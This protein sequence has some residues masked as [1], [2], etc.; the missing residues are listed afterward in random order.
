[1]AE[2]AAATLPPGAI[3]LPPDGGRVYEMNTMR[4]V[5]K[6]DGDETGDRYCVSEW[7]LDPHQPGPG[8]HLHEANDEIFYVLEGRPSM[9]VG[10]RW[11]D[12]PK[13]SLV[14]IPANVLH[15]FENRTDTRIGLLN[16]FIP[17]GFEPMMP[18]IVKWFNEN[19]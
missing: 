5:F 4:A 2:T 11:I 13:G 6:A 1:M 7:W 16:F 3:F 9:L 17:G 14:R 8:A 10:E 18:M 19:R 12:A 15:D